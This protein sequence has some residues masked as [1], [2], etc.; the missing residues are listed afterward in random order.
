[1]YLHIEST[2]TAPPF[3]LDNSEVQA[4]VLSAIIKKKKKYHS[5]IENKVIKLLFIK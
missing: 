5:A 3:I 2:H 4:E 1:M